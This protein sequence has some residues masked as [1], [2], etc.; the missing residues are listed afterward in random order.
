MDAWGEIKAMANSILNNEGE[1]TYD[2]I[3]TGMDNLV[4]LFDAYYGWD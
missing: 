3:Q 4:D 1:Y 2:D